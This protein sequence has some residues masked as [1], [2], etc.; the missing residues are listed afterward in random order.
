[1][2][3]FTASHAPKRRTGMRAWMRMRAVEFIDSSPITRARRGHVIDQS[4]RAAES[5][6]LTSPRR[7]RCPVPIAHAGSALLAPRRLSAT[8]GWSSGDPRRAERLALSELRALL[9][10]EPGLRLGRP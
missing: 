10:H 5:V 8:P 6:I 4:Y 1:M 3:N 7:T 9:H 2:E